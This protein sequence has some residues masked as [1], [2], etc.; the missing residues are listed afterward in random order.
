MIKSASAGNGDTISKWESP[1]LSLLNG[2]DQPPEPDLETLRKQA[3][4]KGYADGLDKG[5]RQSQADHARLSSTLTHLLDAL[6]DP[7]A[8]INEQVL[9]NLAK[10]AGKIAR[11][12]VKRELRT[13]PETIMA[14]V[15]DTVGILSASA[16][17]IHVHLNPADSLLIH[18]IARTGSEKSRW[19]LIDDP[20]IARGDC[21]VTWRDAMIDGNLQTRINTIITQFQ[22][23]ERG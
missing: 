18:A 10:L 16:E 1:A 2:R 7:Y 11:C 6:A 9:D 13:E 21:R 12:L 15:R 3:F 4:E 8:D 23:D 19:E 17:R 14:L 20:L 22:G 5:T